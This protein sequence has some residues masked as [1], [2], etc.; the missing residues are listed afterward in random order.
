MMNRAPNANSLAPQDFLIQPWLLLRVLLL[1]FV[2]ECV[3]PSLSYFCEF[4]KSMLCY[5]S[6]PSCW[7]QTTHHDVQC[8]LR[9]WRRSRHKLPSSCFSSINNSHKLN[10]ADSQVF[11]STEATACLHKQFL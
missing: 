2:L 10:P 6:Q 3:H 11:S 1:G 8:P 5:H 4:G 7:N 9:G